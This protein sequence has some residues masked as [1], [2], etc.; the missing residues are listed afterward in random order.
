MNDE[1]PKVDKG[2][3]YPLIYSTR[4][5]KG[6]KYPFKDMEIG[7]SFFLP[8]HYQDFAGLRSSIMT[9][10]NRFGIKVTISYNAEEGGIRTWRVK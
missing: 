1:V 10:A 8:N 9:A 4:K 3:P 7:D 5:P 2:I 6:S